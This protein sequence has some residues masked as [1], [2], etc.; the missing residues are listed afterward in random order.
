MPGDLFPSN[1]SGTDE[2]DPG[3]GVEEIHLPAGGIAGHA[4]G[5]RLSF[6]DGPEFPIQRFAG[7]ITVP[8]PFD[9]DTDFK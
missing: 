2:I 9:L 3:L 7:H 8:S 6:E 4:D 1:R 5:D